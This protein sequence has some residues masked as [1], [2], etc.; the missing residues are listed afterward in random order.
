MEPRSPRITYGPVPSRRLGRSLG[1]DLVPMKTCSYDCVYCQLGPTPRTR[2]RRCV[3]R[4]PEQV[5]QAVRRALER[6]ARPQVLTLSGSGEPTLDLNMGRTIQA[7][8]AAFDIPVA[9]LTNGS[10]LHHRTVR[11]ELGAADLVLPSLDGWTEPM[12]RRINRPHPTVQLQAILEGLV[13]LRREFKG[14]IWLEVLL[15]QGINDDPADLPGLIQW[16]S[17]ISPERVQ[18]NTVTRPP[19]ESWVRAPSRERLE[20]FC[21][22]LGPRAEIVASFRAATE[23]TSLRDLEERIAETVLRRPLCAQDVCSLFGIDPAQARALLERLA[24]QNSWSTELVGERTYYRSPKAHPQ[25]K[26]PSS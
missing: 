1:I 16:V 19:A 3:F 18:I 8:K 26:E 13:S 17:K 10:L 9:V 2:I 22:A 4:K 6:G 5:V 7:L 21:L 12:F 11:E 15:V 23:S 24:Q 20:E 25:A 14:E